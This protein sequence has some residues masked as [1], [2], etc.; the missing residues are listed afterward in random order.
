MN[1]T[2][3]Y[4]TSFDEVA[5]GGVDSTTWKDLNNILPMLFQTQFLQ[6]SF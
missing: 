5:H 6:C 1:Q 3:K 2:V 4:A